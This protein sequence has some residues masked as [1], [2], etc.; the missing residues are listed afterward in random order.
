MTRRFALL[1]LDERPVNTGLV[2]EVA[3]IAGADCAIPDR[4]SLPDFRTPGDVRRLAS[5]L[6]DRA[7]EADALVIS[8]DT[9]VFGGLIPARTT[10]DPV[11]QAVARLGLLRE[12]SEQHPGLPIHAVSLV[13]RAS[14]SDSAVEEPHYWS[15]HGRDLHRLG[16][17]AHR[18]WTLGE[19]S[20][21]TPAPAA[22]R[23]DFAR[24][25]LRNHVVNLAA[26]ELRWDGVLSYL[27]LTADDT[28]EFSAGSAEQR[29]FDYWRIAAGPGL[30]VVSYPGADETGAVL[31]ARAVLAGTGAPPRVAVHC[32][33][34]ASL[35]RTPLYENG[36]I[37]E[38][39]QR[40]LGAA[41]ARLTEQDDAELALIV[42][43]P[44]PARGD[45]FSLTPPRA[46]P[47][48]V[49]RT[50]GLTATVLGSGLPVALADVRHANG[51][52]AELA[53]ALARRGL[54]GELTA[55][56]GWNTAGNALGSAIAMGLAAVAGRRTGQIDRLAQARALRRRLLDDVAYQS[57][58][59]RELMASG[60]GGRI[61]PVPQDVLAVASGQARERLAEAL[62]AW[63]LADGH[64]VRSVG[65]PWRRSFEIDIELD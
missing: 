49:D 61:D 37:R 27:A 46:D 19:A 21:G 36:P 2:R 57:I 62:S 25:R 64:R 33:D 4:R 54:L 29:W 6:R 31:M 35:D 34:P 38:S 24:R 10:D 55:Y 9:L 7:A 50:A 51:G 28:A 58:A 48:A 63:G 5:W 52:D 44:D 16:R 8:V 32:A 17:E 42:H 11:E 1:P 14:D 53:D 56:G 47:E 23:E 26:L 15:G 65:F 41:G 3:A 12:L 45:H 39:I 20:P 60:F 18:A 40:Q 30:P 13:T 59:R 22:I 43:G